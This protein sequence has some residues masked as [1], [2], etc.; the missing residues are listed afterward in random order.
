[1]GAPNPVAAQSKTEGRAAPSSRSL[2]KALGGAIAALG[3]A[4]LVHALIYLL[5]IINR[6]KLL[7]ALIANGAVWLGRLAGVA[8]IAA[9]VHCA[10]VLTRWLL[11]R[12]SAAFA[13]Q[14][15]PEPRPA[16]A[17]WTGCLVPLVNLAWAPVYAL[18][19]AGREDR[20]DRLRRPIVVWWVVWAVSTG[21]A[22]FATATS[23]ADDAQ[24]IA[25]NMVATVVAYLLGLAA[26]VATARV[27]E[28]FEQRS[29]GRPAH[30]WVV[31]PDGGDTA[32]TV[33]PEAP[34]DNAPSPAP[35]TVATPAAVVGSGGREPAA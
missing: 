6:T 27:V 10:V 32:P 9:V 21:A 7:H 35:E 17:L 20:L 30:H 12:R 4:A 31:V 28:G 1:M 15:L 22:V 23:W 33:P 26:V 25:D 19:L 24:G 29:M 16:W 3:I 8:A 13:R 34:E 2:E 11:A 14:H 18:E 5:M